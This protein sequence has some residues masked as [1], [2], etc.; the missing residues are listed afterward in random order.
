MNMKR[1]TELVEQYAGANGSPEKKLDQAL[2]AAAIDFAKP[3]DA[4]AFATLVDHYGITCPDQYLASYKVYSAQ[5]KAEAQKAK[6][7]ARIRD[8]KAKI[9]A[10]DPVAPGYLED[11]KA[12][13]MEA[14]KGNHQGQKIDLAPDNTETILSRI[15]N[16]PPVHQ[17][18]FVLKPGKKGGFAKNPTEDTFLNFPTGALSFI[19]APSGHGKTTLLMNLLAD[20]SR[21]QASKRHW[22]FSFEEDAAM[23]YLK[24][25]NSWANKQW[26][27]YKGGN[28]TVLERFI[29]EGKTNLFWTP[30]KH[31]I[32]S[33]IED[34]HK[35]WAE[36]FGLVERGT[37]T[38]KQGDFMAED[39]AQGIRDL[40]A[41]GNAGLV[42][43]DYAQLLYL[44][45][46]EKGAARTEELKQIM[47]ILK[48]V[49]I[50]TG[51]PII[52]AAQF[53]RQ[54]VSAFHMHMTKIADAADIERVAALII[55]LWNGNK[56]AAMG[57]GEGQKAIE[58]WN[59]EAGIIAQTYEDET[60][61]DNGTVFLRI[62]KDRNG[63][64]ESWASYP[65]SGGKLNITRTPS[66]YGHGDPLIGRRKPK[67]NSQ[68]D[69]SIDS[70]KK[71]TGKVG[72][73]GKRGPL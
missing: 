43:I 59:D 1:Y 52:L 62:M 41:Q 66:K 26:G 67:V 29:K 19:V 40:H 22:L 50:E 53:N 55:G 25:F 12:L 45:N 23:V 57:E 56:S 9:D 47:L 24:T 60:P 3:E 20:A 2:K 49:A 70:E 54:V 61:Q 65:L 35:K 68:G 21:D 69:E 37:I 8:I 4:E 11:L 36:F 14:G 46:P 5:A 17:S 32:N 58:K 63:A 27:R 71:D 15:K 72:T 18:R 42:L 73:P 10:L 39:L 64:S 44:D 48:D 28:M 6:D 38:I 31:T 16:K 13:T 30:E 51:L 7:E 33:H 34:F